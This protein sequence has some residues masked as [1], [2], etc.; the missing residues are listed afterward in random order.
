M[1]IIRF[2]NVSKHF[3]EDSYGLRE[4]S[5]TID[6]GEFLFITGQSGSGKTTLLRL[7]LKEYEISSGEVY[8]HD[9]PVSEIQM[10][11]VHHHRRKIGMV[12]QDYKLIPEMNIWENIALPL[13]AVGKNMTE[14]EQRVTDLLNL[15]H[16]PEKALY[17]PGQLSG[18]E[19]Q[20]VGIARALAVGPEIV[21]ADEPTG[22][23]DP[24][25]ASA[26]ARLLKKINELGTTVL[27][28]THD[29]NII[30]QYP[31]ARI[32]VL[33]KGIL[34]TDTQTQAASPDTT[35][36]PKATAKAAATKKTDTKTPTANTP[37][38][39]EEKEE[40]KETQAEPKASF[41]QRVFGKKAQTPATPE[42]DKKTTE[43][44]DITVVIEELDE[45]VTPDDTPIKTDDKPETKPASKKS[46]TH[47]KAQEK[48]KEGAA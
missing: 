28:A 18:G 26:I 41:W 46:H 9:Q 40:T 27:V 42:T 12:F 25:T 4:V 21:I 19:A 2:E 24:E 16:L 30:A 39:I 38:E 29:K 43:A 8:L 13:S 15:I 23:L 17:F 20:R 3:G 22:N 34:N 10:S 35:A 14:I 7:L 6:P 32:L 33:D 1:P 45:P 44:A 37:E 31:E 47:K 48:S 11:Q 36:A 5:F